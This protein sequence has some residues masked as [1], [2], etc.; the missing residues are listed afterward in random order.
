MDER[1]KLG[2]EDAEDGSAIELSEEDETGGSE[3]LDCENRVDLGDEVFTTIT[4]EELVDASLGV[5]L[6]GITLEDC[7]LEDAP[8]TLP[9]GGGGGGGGFRV[10]Q[11]GLGDCGG[12]L[13]RCSGRRRR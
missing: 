11:A 8:A 10:G 2:G 13:L 6:S 4:G 12:R 5:D 1:A 7:A 9:L 3:E